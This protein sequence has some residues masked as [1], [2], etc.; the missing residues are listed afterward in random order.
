MSHLKTTSS[1]SLSISS[2]GQ[3]ASMKAAV[4]LQK[5]DIPNDPLAAEQGYFGNSKYYQKR[6]YIR[7]HLLGYK[8]KNLPKCCFARPDPS[9]S[10]G[11]AIASVA[12]LTKAGGTHA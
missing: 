9:L 7:P 12:G 6:S 1:N 3:T 10:N 2:T 4:Y 8:H 11:L 5:S